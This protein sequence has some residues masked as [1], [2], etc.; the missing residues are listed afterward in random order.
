LDLSKSAFETLYH[1]DGPEIEQVS[2][3]ERQIIDFGKV[4]SKKVVQQMM[5]HPTENKVEASFTNCSQ[6]ESALTCVPRDV[7]LLIFLQL[8]LPDLNCLSRTCKRFYAGL[9]KVFATLKPPKVFL[10]TN[11]RS[12]RL[13]HGHSHEEADGSVKY[14]FDEM[15]GRVW[16]KKTNKD[17]ELKV[18]HGVHPSGALSVIDFGP[19]FLIYS[20]YRSTETLFFCLYKE[21]DEIM[22][23]G[24][25]ELQIKKF[26][27]H[28]S[29]QGDYFGFGFVS[30]SMVWEMRLIESSSEGEAEL[31]KGS[32][33]CFEL[34][35]GSNQFL[36]IESKAMQQLSECHFALLEDSGLHGHFTKHLKGKLVNINGGEWWDQLLTYDPVRRTWDER[37]CTGYLMTKTSSFTLF[38]VSKSRCLMIP[39]QNSYMGHMASLYFVDCNSANFVHVSLGAR[40]LLGRQFFC[41]EGGGKIYSWQGNSASML[42]IDSLPVDETCFKGKQEIIEGVVTKQSSFVLAKMRNR[43]LEMEGV[44]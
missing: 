11:V 44:E 1:S 43:F 32:E 42:Y 12:V 7:L 8:D 19:K 17:V 18:P 15:G 14:M 23:V 6:L 29:D 40:R 16:L 27:S 22:L 26:Y 28:L 36:R 9:A 35:E 21:T 3:E 20:V 41:S 5:H 25:A 38:P 13:M 30:A 34:K 4:V 24:R 37:Q 2:E 33:L 39:L 10:I 31:K